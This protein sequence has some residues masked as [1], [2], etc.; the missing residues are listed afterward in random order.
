MDLFRQKHTPQAEWAIPEGGSGTRVC[1]CQCL[2]GWVISQANEWEEYSNYM[3]EG[4]RI[5]RSWATAHFLTF[6]VGLGTV[7]V[8]VGVLLN[9][10]MCCNE[11]IRRLKT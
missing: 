5:S 7:L 6:L 10:P 1:G 9:L 11:N 8:P 2:Q 3:G 4:V